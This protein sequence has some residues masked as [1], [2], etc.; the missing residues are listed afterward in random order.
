MLREDGQNREELLTH[1]SSCCLTNTD[2]SDKGS[3]ISCESVTIPAGHHK[4]QEIC[5]S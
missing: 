5:S 3:N 1:S 4:C 2:S